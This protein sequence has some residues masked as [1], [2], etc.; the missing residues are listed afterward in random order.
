MTL[1]EVA[2]A[3]TEKIWASAIAEL[4]GYSAT[5]DTS[6]ELTVNVT[7]PGGEAF[8]I[9]TKSYGFWPQYSATVVGYESTEYGMCVIRLADLNDTTI[10]NWFTS[11]IDTL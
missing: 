3:S 5:F 7:A 9:N 6:G 8:S 1:L 4:P 2:N 10:R 11:F